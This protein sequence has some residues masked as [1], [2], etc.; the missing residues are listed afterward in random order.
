[1]LAGNEAGINNKNVPSKFKLYG[2]GGPG[3]Q[4]NLKAKGDFFGA[5][6][7]PNADVVINAGGDIYGSF[8]SSNFELKSGGN[9]YYDEALKNVGVDDAAVRFVLKNWHEH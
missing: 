5:V 1:L 6:Y 7:A 9:F 2:T 4:L 8:V 3:Q